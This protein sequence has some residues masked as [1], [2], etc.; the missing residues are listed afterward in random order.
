M[1]AARFYTGLPIQQME[2]KMPDTMPEPPRCSRNQIIVENLFMV[3][4]EKLKRNR[5]QISR[6]ARAACNPPGEKTFS[7]PKIH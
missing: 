6:F 5:L 7:C 1:A 4:M 2:A 3:G